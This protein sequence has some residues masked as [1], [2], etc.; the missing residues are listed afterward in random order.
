MPK[1]VKLHITFS[2]LTCTIANWHADWNVLMDPTHLPT[3]PT[4]CCFWLVGFVGCILCA[5]LKLLTHT[6]GLELAVFGGKQN[7]PFS[8][9]PSLLLHSS[10]IVSVGGTTTGLPCHMPC[11]L[12]LMDHRHCTCFKHEQV[13]EHAVG[14]DDV[15]PG[16]FTGC[17]Y[18]AEQF[19]YGV[20]ALCSIVHQPPPAAFC[21]QQGTTLLDSWSCQA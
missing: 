4:L 20:V 12:F 15:W 1:L 9:S 7:G 6:V 14:N 18:T 19:H 2:L 3:R 10:L 16:N 5:W 8:P 21:M 11:W 17:M 13:T